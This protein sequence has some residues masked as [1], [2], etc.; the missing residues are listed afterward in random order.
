MTRKKRNSL[1]LSNLALSVLLLGLFRPGFA[2]ATDF[3]S[4]HAGSWFDA[5]STWG[6]SSN[7]GNGDNVEISAAVDYVVFDPSTSGLSV[8]ISNLYL[9]NGTL[10]VDSSP[11]TL[12]MAGTNSLFSGNCFLNGVGGV[13][14]NQ[15]TVF[16]S[17]NGP[18]NIGNQTTFENEIAGTYNLEGDSGV[19]GS[20]YSYFNNYGLLRKIGGNGISLF[21]SHVYFN[22]LNG[23]IEVD[24]GTLSLATAGISSSG[25]FIVASGALLDL[26]GG[27]DP[28]WS[29]LVNGSG[30]GTVSLSSGTLH[31]SPSLTLNLPD[32]L[33]Q[34]TGGTLSGTTINANVITV[35]G[36]GSVNINGVF[37]N[38]GLLH[39]TNTATLNLVNNTTFENQAGGIYNL[40]GDGGVVGSGYFNNSGLL[41]KSG[42]NGTSSFNSSF[43]FDNLNG[44]IEVDSGTL[45]LAGSG[46][47]SNGTFI[48]ASGAVLDLTSVNDPYW[49]GLVAGSGAG[50]VSLRS[51]TLHTSP[52]LTLN[53]PDG[54][55]QWTGGTLSG[56][57]IN[58]NVITVA[59]S[60]SVYVNNVFYNR[61]LIRHTNTATLNVVNTTTFENQAG[62]IYNLEGD[63]GVAGSGYFNNSGLLRKSGG[64]GTSIFNGISFNNQNGSIEVDSG[65]LSLNG[66][67]YA[68]GSGSLIVTLG[69]T[70]VGQFGQLVCGSATL[71]GPLQVKLAGGFVPT[72]GDQ[73]QIISCSGL[74][75]AFSSTNLPAGI[76]MSYSNNGVYLIMMKPAPAQLLNPVVTDGNF[77]FAFDTVNSQSYT[78]QHN[79][80]LATTNWISDT[81]FTGNG[82]LMQVLT[83]ITNVPMRFYRVRDP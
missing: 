3:V 12:T 18:L 29:G 2:G 63:G 16:Q 31:A 47:S 60:G 25:T 1:T 35:A 13:L 33:F 48:V 46:V 68:Q 24:S 5:A 4:L 74:A 75:G 22:N 55:F 8:T 45:N 7:P 82:S 11:S 53:L 36:S 58:S 77:T 26:T 32:G 6:Q 73:F 83:P 66:Q 42:G 65:Q 51:G 49:A 81:N 30:A 69:G 57:T 19:T 34:W 52:S 9:Y 15:G 61:G 43:G 21:N 78:I 17:S 23:V 38:N 20:G 44:T 37:Y 79:D 64:N 80:D 28:Y 39:Q 41:R 70:N 59:G 10:W 54:L 14:H 67:G 76:S 56:A 62:G 27:N 50:T 71:D 40:E 72:P